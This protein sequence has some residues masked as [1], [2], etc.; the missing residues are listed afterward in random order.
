MDVHF[1]KSGVLA[2]AAQRAPASASAEIAVDRV[3]SAQRTFVLCADDYGIAPGVDRAI[4][5]LIELRRVT[6]TSAMV[7]LPCWKRD[8]PDLAALARATGAHVGL[9][10]TLTEQRAAS[11]ARGLVQ[12]GRLPA[13][14]SLLLRALA[15]RLPEAAVA[16]EIRAQFDAFEDAWG[17]PPAFVD[18]HQHVHLLPTVREALV[19][20][21]LRR[22]APGTLWVR[23]CRETVRRIRARGVGVRKALFLRRLGRGLKAALLA[24]GIAHNQ[25]FS[26]LHDFKE[27]PPFREKMSRF[28]SALGP[29][30]LVHVHPGRVDAALLAVDTLT[31]P[32]EWE[33][34]YLASEAFVIDCARLGVWPALPSWNGVPCRAE[35][36]ALVCVA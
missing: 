17:A 13:L 4:E 3:V 32:R 35:E 23:D 24:H 20:E 7:T 30:A 26:G 10:L 9:H 34:E 16:E 8:A 12:E 33:Y 21:I 11:P 28:L 18:G 36:N 2:V 31:T 14:R 6:A 15:R 29:K 25:G 22:Y 5:H 27:T 19:A 1:E